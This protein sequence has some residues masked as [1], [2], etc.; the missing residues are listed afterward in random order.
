MGVLLPAASRARQGFPA[1]LARECEEPHGSAGGG[2]SAPV[3]PDSRATRESPTE[4]R[5]ICFF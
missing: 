3:P 2:C 1:H 4:K 5:R